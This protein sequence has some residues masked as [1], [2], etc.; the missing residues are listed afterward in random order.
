VRACF[1]ELRRLTESRRDPIM[2]QTHDRPKNLVA[3]AADDP[4][5]A[6]GE[7]VSFR[8]SELKKATPIAFPYR[9]LTPHRRAES[10]K[11]EAAGEA[12]FHNGWSKSWSFRR[13]RSSS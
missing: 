3:L 12:G 2:I 5:M 9:L 10:M 11:R 7:L 13:H 6:G 1:G 4:A 8:F